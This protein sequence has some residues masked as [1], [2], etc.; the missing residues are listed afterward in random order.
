M[1]VTE[2]TYRTNRNLGNYETE[3]VELRI[4]LDLEDHPG[5]ALARA[6]QFCR[7]AFGQAPLTQEEEARA[8]ALMFG[9]SEVAG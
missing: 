3:H 4:E 1:R 8:Q 2:L 6:R 5:Q 9:A 7:R